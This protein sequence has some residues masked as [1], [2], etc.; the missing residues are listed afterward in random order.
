MQNY[1][2]T[3]LSQYANSPRILALIDAM[4]AYLDPSADIEALRTWVWDLDQAQGFG[5]DLWGRILGL[6]RTITALSTTYTLDD[7]SYRTMLYVK[8]AANICATTA[9]ALNQLFTQ[10]FK[11]QDVNP[12]PDRGRAYVVDLGNMHMLYVFEFVLSAFDFA[13]MKY[14]NLIPHPAGVRFDIVQ[15]NGEPIFGFDLD[16]YLISGFETGHWSA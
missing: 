15:Y 12:A 13:I 10:L 1:Q 6:K 3:I 11:P 16:T 9:P 8:A 4:N 14:A 5:L 7:A 2:A